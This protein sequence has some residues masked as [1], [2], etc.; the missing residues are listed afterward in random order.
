MV[1]LFCNLHF[2]WVIE[3]PTADTMQPTCAPYTVMHVAEA[4]S[5]ERALAIVSVRSPLNGSVR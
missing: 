4:C 2:D 1:E 5:A 3:S